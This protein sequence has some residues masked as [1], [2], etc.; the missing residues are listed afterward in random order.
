MQLVKAAGLE[1]NGMVELTEKQLV[2]KANVA[3]D[4]MRLQAEDKPVG[5]QFMGVS[6][7]NGMGEVMYE[8][9]ME[10]VAEWLKGSDVM[11]AFIA[12]WGQ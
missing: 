9:D 7:L 6:K 2:E 5:T 11:K 10:E 12:Q 4:L 3:L 1:A 8:M